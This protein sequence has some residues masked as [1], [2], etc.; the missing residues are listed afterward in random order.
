MKR[1]NR[2]QDAVGIVGLGLMGGS[3][4][5]ALRRR[6]PRRVLIGVEPGT[7]TR[8]LARA[9]GIFDTLLPRPSDELSRCGIVVLC[10]P[11]PAIL[12]L[13]G[14]VSRTMRDGAILTDVGGVKKPIVDGAR[15]RV[16]PGVAFVGAHPMFGGESGGYAGA[17][18]D[19]WQG[20]TVAV[21][22]D[23]GDRESERQAARLHRSLGARIVVCTAAEHDAA[24]AAV[25][26]LPYLVA[27]A[28]ALTARAAGPLAGRL[29]GRGM[30][31]VTRPAGFAYA[32]QGKAARANSRLPQA[33]RSF[34]RELR[35]LAGALTAGTGARRLFSR[36]RAARKRF[37]SKSPRPTR[38]GR[39]STRH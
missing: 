6:F 23:G 13:L 26:H 9:S 3:L 4:A 37:R 15:R 16:R 22:T 12:R 36:A 33:T 19:L 7:R 18:E 21:C 35:R 29:A 14:P 27:S 28:L 10:A 17:R 5:R 11:V 38:E 8:A 20:G 1:T 32:I 31:D 2:A 24:V 34:E 39:P 25:S 30:A